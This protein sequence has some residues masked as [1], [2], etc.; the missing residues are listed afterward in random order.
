MQIQVCALPGRGW[1]GQTQRRRK[2][3]TRQSAGG[4][5]CAVGQVPGA[6]EDGEILMRGRG[7]SDLPQSTLLTAGETEAK[8]GQQ[9]LLLPEYHSEPSLVPLLS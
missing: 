9:R 8:S 2:R 4:H 7:A 1:M 5:L 3:T 6:E